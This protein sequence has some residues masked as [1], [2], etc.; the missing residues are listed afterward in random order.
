M[1]KITRKGATVE[2]AIAAA[3]QELNVTREEVDIEIVD[4]GKK[5]FL[6]FGAR[7]AEVTVTLKEPIK[8]EAKELEEKKENIQAETEEP[9]IGDETVAQAV[10]LAMQTIE[11]EAKDP[12]MSDEQAINETKAY[13]TEIA[14][15]MGIDD[16]VVKHEMDGK[17]LSFQLESEKAAYLI[18]KRGQTLNALQQLAQLVANKTSEQFKVVRLDVGDYRER[19]EQSLEQ[20]AERM[21]DQAVR[22]GRKVQLEPMPSYERKVIH[23]ALS[24]RLDIETYSEGTDPNRYLVIEPIS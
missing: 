19:R 20:F 11:A 4:A 12:A 17:Y 1:K 8:Q 2:V 21:A 16:L 7:E 15:A 5:G 24:N 18:G 22:N 14:K 9:P 23:N 10:E 6:G 13:V 3:L